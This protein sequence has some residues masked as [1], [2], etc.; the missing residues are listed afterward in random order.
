[1]RVLAH[2]S[3]HLL[4]P[5]FLLPNNVLHEKRRGNHPREDQ[6][7]RKEHRDVKPELYGLSCSTGHDVRVGVDT[8]IRFLLSVQPAWHGCASDRL[9]D[10]A[11]NSF[12]EEGET[13]RNVL[14]VHPRTVARARMARRVDDSLGV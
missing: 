7:Q 1:M 6:E 10:I 2:D 9:D 12:L 11:F 8:R 4:Q 3:H 13:E 5:H 14:E